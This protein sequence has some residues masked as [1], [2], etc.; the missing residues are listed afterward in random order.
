MTPIFCKRA[1]EF[2]DCLYI[3][4]H[5]G[6]LKKNIPFSDRINEFNKIGTCR[7]SASSLTRSTLMLS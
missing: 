1:N 6:F 3:I 4:I 7:F 5:V 2:C